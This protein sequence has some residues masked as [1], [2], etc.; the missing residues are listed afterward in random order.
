MKTWLY[1]S[2]LL[3]LARQSKRLLHWAVALLVAG[4]ILLFSGFAA[5][6]LIIVLV[7]EY[8]PSAVDLMSGSLIDQSAA[9]VAFW[10]SM[11]L[12]LS[13]G[14]MFVLLAAWLRWVEKR[15]LSTLGLE[16]SGWWKK[17]GRGFG[18]GILMMA[19]VAGILSL[20]GSVRLEEVATLSGLPAALGGVLVIVPGW[21][22]QG[23]AEEALTRGWLLPVL[24]V[25][26]RPWV[27]IVLSSLVFA[28]FHSLNPNL[29]GL[30]LVNLA[31]FGLFAALYALREGSLWGIAAL[32]SAWNWAQGNLFGLE[33]SGTSP[34]GGALLNLM[35]S[36]PDWLTGGAF[37]PEA[38]LA[39][40]LVLC[41]GIV[42][43][44]FK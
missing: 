31:L 19:S 30:A 35:E 16:Q 39:V 13:F 14:G 9:V 11:L 4:I 18:I 44:W 41:L 15:P 33:V 6:P 28:V 25:R 7:I 3:E 38:G 32:H 12:I 43:L 34:M 40:T 2:R 37:G 36:G 20:S 27:G 8:G 29:N 42:L 21:M 26:Y 1:E 22:V 23:A 24:A 10:Q 17:Y 5:V